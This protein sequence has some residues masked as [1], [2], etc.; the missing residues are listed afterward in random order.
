[1][2]L[3]GLDDAGQLVLS[4]GLQPAIVD[5]SMGVAVATWRRIGA[6]LPRPA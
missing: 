6:T 3:A 4:S 2:R 1:M 5:G